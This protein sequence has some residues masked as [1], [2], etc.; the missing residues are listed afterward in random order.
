MWTIDTTP[1]GAK[2]N[3]TRE[4]AGCKIHDTMGLY[5]MISRTMTADKRVGVTAYMPL[6]VAGVTPEVDAEIDAL[7]ERLAK[8]VLPD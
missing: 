1:D 5:V 6:A 7:A 3:R 4:H 2:P 8:V